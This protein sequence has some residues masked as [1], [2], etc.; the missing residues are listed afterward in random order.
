[1]CFTFVP[2]SRV[3]LPAAAQTTQTGAVLKPIRHRVTRDVGFKSLNFERK[4]HYV[5]FT[6]ARLIATVLATP[7]LATPKRS[8]RDKGM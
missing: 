8:R 7:G 4:L 1:M 3:S 6:M 5:L 2:S